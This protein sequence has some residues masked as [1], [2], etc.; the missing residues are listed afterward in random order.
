VC[1]WCVCF[2]VFC[3]CACVHVCDVCACVCVCVLY[4]LVCAVCVV[5]QPVIGKHLLV[6]LN[7]ARETWYPCFVKTYPFF[8]LNVLLYMKMPI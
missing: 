5:C 1:V 2:C 4:V 3:V 7:R 8:P 6:F